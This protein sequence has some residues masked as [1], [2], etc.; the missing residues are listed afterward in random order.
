MAYFLDENCFFL[1][2]KQNEHAVVSHAK[3]VIIVANKASKMM[4]GVFGSFFKLTDDSSC[5][6]C[7][8]V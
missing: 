1:V 7:L 5:N 6:F 2:Q 8:K 4:I 3:L